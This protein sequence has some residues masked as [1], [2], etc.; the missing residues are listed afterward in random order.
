[1]RMRVLG[2]VAG[3]LTAGLALASCGS[4][5]ANG[6]AGVYDLPL[7]GGAAL[8]AHPY[9][10][11]ADFANVLDL[12]PQAAVKVNE[13]AVGRVTSIGLPPD[14]WTAEVTMQIN[15][16]VHLPANAIAYLGQ[17]SLLGEKYVELSAPSGT[18]PVGAL[19]NG[20]VIPLSRTSRG[21]EVEEVLGALS[22]LLNG[23]GIGQLQTITQ[24]L[25]NALSGNEPQIR[26]LLSNVNTLVAN[27]NARR[28]DI[29]QALDGLNRL[30]A[31]LADR[32][33]QIGNV[34]DNLTPGLAVLDQ[35]RDEL[36]T[37]LNTLNTLSGV[38]V[39]TV[40][41]TQQ[42]LVADLTALAPTL[43][44]LAQAGQAL[45]QALQIL[46]SY[47]FTDAVTGGI[48]GDYLNVYLSLAAPPSANLTLLPPIKSIVTTTGTA[49][50]AKNAPILPLTSIGSSQ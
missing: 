17:T 9:T 23:G 40:N 7:P 18:A 35:Q 30:S 10:V 29:T 25:N 27:L 21:P 33:Q 15:G 14:G 20:A 5:S 1:M 4:G 36:V 22:L 48:K 2:L 45:P 24:Q 31:T 26:D 3:L 8:G 16:D 39:S 37:M 11:K 19:A 28:D 41:A 34:L 12:V 6:F 38:T 32:D 46:L 47:P 50:N 42:D 44:E 49:A 43:K 13:V